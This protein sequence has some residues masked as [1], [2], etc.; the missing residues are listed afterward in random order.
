MYIY[1][2]IYI[3]NVYIYVYLYKQCVYIDTHIWNSKGDYYPNILY[4]SLLMQITN[5]AHLNKEKQAK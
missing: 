2:R 4:Q 3:N 1:E 5:I